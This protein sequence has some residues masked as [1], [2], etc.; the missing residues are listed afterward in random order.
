MANKNK[1]N[2]KRNEKFE[3]AYTKRGRSDSSKS[4]S[5]RKGVDLNSFSSND[6]AYYNKYPEDYR[7]A[8]QTPG[9]FKVLGDHIDWSAVTGY[10]SVT[11]KTPV[12]GIMV[13]DFIPGIG[14]AETS[15]DPVNKAFSQVMADIYAKTTG[16]N[17]GFQQADLAMLVTSLASISNMIGVAQRALETTE[18][19]ITKNAYTPKKMATAMGF[20]WQDLVKNK[21]AYVQRLNSLTHMYNN[22]K[23]PE[24]L[25]V[26]KRQYALSHT[27]YIDED[28]SFAQIYMFMPRGYYKYSDVDHKCAWS[29]LKF[30]D[31]H[32]MDHFSRLLDE[33]EDAITIWYNSSDLYNMNG[34][35]LRAYKESSFYMISDLTIDSL[36]DPRL[37]RYI[38]LQ[39]M[40]ADF[41]NYKYIRKDTLDIT[42]DVVENIVIWKPGAKVPEGDDAFGFEERS[43]HLVRAYDA[44]VSADD[45]CELT[46]FMFHTSLVNTVSGESWYDFDTLGTEIL[47]GIHVYVGLTTSTAGLLE[48]VDLNSNTELLF[49]DS[50]SLHKV[51]IAYSAFRY[52]PNIFIQTSDGSRAAVLGDMYNY[53]QLS[54]ADLKQM[55]T[56]FALSMWK[57]ISPTF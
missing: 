53:T 52:L 33:I 31:G 54:T 46:R 35:L 1:K 45:N 36:I 51:I 49:A 30:R 44:E 48:S 21:P 13:L 24:F 56:T 47:C 8:T 39:L 29:E 19:W 42:Q 4:F 5:N 3:P 18:F 28:S 16:S 15:T 9:W 27:V 38:M 50:D 55:N 20:S 17:L 32:Y 26:Y 6:P 43:S 23:I 12:P 22:I 10:A 25:D 41:C 11:A 40:N 7:L 14:I 37:D 34:T 2:S 57:P